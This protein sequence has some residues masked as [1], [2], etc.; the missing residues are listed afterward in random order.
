MATIGGA[1][2]LGRDDI[3]SLEIGRCADLVAVSLDRIRFAGALHDPVAALVFTQ[4]G[5]VDHSWVQGLPVITHGA[6][7]AMDLEAQIA[8]HNQAA[9]RLVSGG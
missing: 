9:R 2:V 7:V 4:P 1:A 3:G 8:E 5:N 6:P